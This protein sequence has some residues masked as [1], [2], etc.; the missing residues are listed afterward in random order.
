M[1][2]SKTSKTI[3]V[4]LIVFG[5]WMSCGTKKT[6]KKKQTVL[7]SQS[8]IDL[9][10]IPEGLAMKLSDGKEQFERRS[11]STKNTANSKL[12][13]KEA[14]SLL[15]RLPL[16]REQK[17]DKKDFALRGSSKP[18]PR[19]GKTVQQS[20]PPPSQKSSPSSQQSKPLE[21]IRFA[22]EGNV[23][24][25]PHISI[26]FNKPMV[27][28]TSQ[29][30]AAQTIPAQL[31][32]DVPGK[33]RWLGTKT[34]HFDP[35]V[36]MPMATD[37]K[38]EL[39]ASTKSIDGK[40]LKSPISFS[41]STPT[42]NIVDSLPG[43][44]PQPLSPLIAI[45]FDQK[46]EPSE[47]IKHIHLKE[48]SEKFDVRLATQEEI[49]SDKKA[50][51]FVKRAQE[52]DQQD[53][54]IVFKSVV[55]LPKDK[56]VHVVIEKG[57]PSAEGNRTTPSELNFA[58]KTH[59]PFKIAR[60]RCSLGG[61]TDCRPGTPWSIET[62]NPIDEKKFNAKEFKLSPFFKG[63]RISVRDRTISVEGPSK[64][65][66]QYTINV[67][68]TLVDVFGQTIQG[69]VSHDIKTGD[70]EPS[71]QGPN[72]LIV[73]DPYATKATFD[74]HSVNIKKLNVKIYKVTPNDWSTYTRREYNNPRKK[75][76]PPGTKVFDGVMNVDGPL[77]ELV[78]T[79]IDLK[80]ALNNQGL[81][82]AIVFVEPTEWP[83][84]YK[85][86]IQTWVQSTQIGLDAFAHHGETLV[87]ATALK[88]GKALSDVKVRTNQQ[89]NGRTNSEGLARLKR[90]D[91]NNIQ[92]TA[93]RNGDSAFLPEVWSGWGS[94][95]DQLQWFV[96]D[97]R[98]MY[99]PSEKVTVK[100]WLRVRGNKLGGDIGGL[101]KL[102]SK[103]SYEVFDS[104]N[105][106]LT[107][108]DTAVNKNGGF[109]L[110]FQ[111]P[112]TPNLG[113]ASIRFKTSASLGGTSIYHGFQIQEFRRP[114]YEVSTKASPGPYIIGQSVDV[115]A[116]AAYYAG[117]GLKGADIS[118]NVS[119]TPTSFSPPNQKEFTFGFWTPWWGWHRNQSSPTSNEFHQSTTDSSGKHTLN[120]DLLSAKPARPM[121]VTA[122]AKVTDVNRQQW[123]S[124]TSLL[125]HPGDYYI[126]L[127]RERYFVEKGKPIKL[128]TLIVDQDGKPVEGVSASIE[129]SLL[130][131]KF[132][133]GNFEE[134]EIN[135]QTCDVRSTPKPGQC[136]FETPEGGT[137]QVVATVFDS[138]N[139]PSQTKLTV[140]VTG[141][142][143]KPNRNVEQELVTIV[144]DK[145]EYVDG[146][147]AKLF[148]QS[149][150]FPAE[151]IL[152]LRRSGIVEERRFSLKDSSSITLDIPLS[153]NHV[154]NIIA[155]VDVVGSAIRMSD[156]GK[157]MPKAP[158]RPAF[159]SGQINLK[160]PPTQRKLT[161]KT[162]PQ[163]KKLSPGES[164]SID[165]A[166]TNSNGQPVKGAEVALVVVDEA[167]LGLTG[168]TTPDPLAFFYALRG[169]GASDYHQ[170]RYLQ[171]AKLDPSLL[172]APAEKSAPE[173]EGMLEDAEFGAAADMMMESKVMPAAS[174]PLGRS[175]RKLKTG[176][177]SPKKSNS[178]KDDAT[179]NGA[180]IAIR[181]NFDA[182]AH[183]SPAVLT[184]SQGKATAAVKVPDNLTRYRVMAIAASGQNHFGSGESSITARM[185]LMVRPSAPRFLNFGDSFEFPVVV[186][187]QTDQDMQVKVAIRATNANLKDGLGRKVLVPANN[188]V[189]VTLPTET[190]KPGKA[191]FQIVATSGKFSDAAELDLPVWSPATT[192]AFATYGEMDKNSQMRQSIKAPSDAI[193]LFGGLQISTASTQLQALTDAFVYLMQYPYECAEQTSSRVLAISALNDVLGAFEADGLPNTTEIKKILTRDVKRLSLLQNYDGGF[194]W[195]IRG[196]ESWPFISIYGSHALARAQKEGVE[197]PGNMIE[198]SKNYLSRIEN[199]IPSFYSERTKRMLKAYAL[200]VRTLHGDADIAKANALLRSAELKEFPLEA[201]GWIIMAM[202]GNAGTQKA[203]SG[204]H[205]YLNNQITE[206]AKSAHWTTSYSD[207]AHL[208]LHSARRTDGVLLQALIQD[209]PQSDLIPK[210]VRGLLAHRTKGRWGNTQENTQ[211]LM[212][213][214]AYFNAFEK[215]TP[216]FAVEMWLG[217]EYAGKTNFKGRSTD[218]N[219]LNIP[220]SSLGSTSK[221]LI[222]DKK[223]PGRL[224]YRLGMKYAP[225][226]LKQKAA[227]YGFSVQRTYEA[228]DD[229]NDVT[230]NKDGSWTIKSGAQVRVKL[231]M[232][233]EARRY[234]VALVDPIPAGLEPLNPALKVSG[235]IP[236]NPTARKSNP[237]WHWQHTWYEHQN[238]RDE[239][240]EAF[241][242]YLSAGV[243]EYTYVARATTPGVFVVPPAKAEEMYS[244]ETFGRSGSEKVIVK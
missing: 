149:P 237:W 233:A 46:I 202:S 45:R 114:E 5:S 133:N 17:D 106:Q 129:A 94:T 23:P 169:A 25:A 229:P 16:L 199:Y 154:P 26:T 27:A 183:F 65:R 29:E 170:R 42:L 62:T 242:S 88:D 176:K 241:A 161:V 19:T 234:H 214:D 145:E 116:T 2:Q 91:N 224:Y 152:T 70:A 123:A 21:V 13:D 6:N 153:E 55:H 222:I 50:S 101:S 215:I 39:P 124:S 77:D 182:L 71:L 201:L 95:S 210:V 203:R 177:A 206:T 139:R 150:F 97:D 148:V 52:A 68:S 158:R 1:T 18:P 4:F 181:K 44:E 205:R 73:L 121:S 164:T 226:S 81:G 130:S 193:K 43:S 207:G 180:S 107:R 59:G 204:I 187:N 167:V 221:E 134:I 76:S 217:K 173:A 213:M 102:P 168:Y 230:K 178:R 51:A 40:T 48:G 225:T 32:P 82:H 192:E 58:F 56:Y 171:L 244:P 34:L 49:E 119:A 103:V 89:K 240:V 223:G 118:W 36:R 197:I 11:N 157:E 79:Q 219:Q 142:K 156:D 122:E 235:S 236:V 216:N 8:A 12:S 9:K 185:P 143:Q 151:G 74:V 184:D 63:H 132:K 54:T 166:V 30:D 38:V 218:R 115:T 92:I 47:L 200:Y 14:L 163:S 141:G 113:Q 159:A 188:R 209:K 90:S 147:S 190:V 99:K 126:G 220:M 61:L 108:G 41:F 109:D 131:W 20:F 194:A 162:M 35:K 136:S 104:R 160:V 28:V 117:G 232:V 135:R 228:I 33:W 175:A 198:K 64:A 238:M 105:N 57:A 128:D 189:E 125:V 231:T 127:K 138:K 66:T 84:K 3:F 191:R 100:G 111:L 53:W 155:Q 165:L 93:E 174:A 195:W 22:P 15:S 196:H 110:A 137:Y 98:K 24:V 239:R 7:A 86:K 85:P 83:H 78:E 243:H 37:Y 146:E 10:D 212:G 31:T 112:K 69:D 172:P 96:F 140:W 227:D 208:I 72:H 67:P 87:W 80:K 186:Q 120:I 144:P 75:V 211:V 179:S 60:V